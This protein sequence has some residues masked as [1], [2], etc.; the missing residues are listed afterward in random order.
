MKWDI[1]EVVGSGKSGRPED[2]KT[3]SREVVGMLD[4]LKN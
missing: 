4:I 1:E 2:R 3:G